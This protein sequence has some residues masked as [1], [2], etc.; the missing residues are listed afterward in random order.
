M[1]DRL[2]HDRPVGDQEETI[3]AYVD[4]FVLPVKKDR[5]EDY[6]KMAELGRT[7]WMDHGAL[8]YVEAM[9]DDV[10]YGELTSFPRAVQAADDEICFFSFITYES[11]EKRDEINAKVMADPRMKMDDGFQNPFDMK[12]MIFGGFKAV[13]ES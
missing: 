12:R 7:V 1:S 5:I 9:A 11:R 6:R 2:G 8:S 13:V 10:P 3:M 4:G